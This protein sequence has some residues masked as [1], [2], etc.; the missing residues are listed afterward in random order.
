M[1]LSE[2]T[3]KQLEVANRIAVCGLLGRL[4]LGE[5]EIMVGALE[6]GISLVILDESTARDKAKQLGLDV[7]GT[8]GVLLNARK[9]GLVEDIFEEIEKL[10]QEG[11]YLS[12]S[13][14]ERIRKSL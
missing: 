10:K 3:F 11:M 13:V 12:D 8:L 9:R 7:T 2:T 1:K 14:V 6:K 5:V 4:H